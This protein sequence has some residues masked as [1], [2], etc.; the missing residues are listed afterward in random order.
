MSWRERIVQSLLGQVHHFH[1]SLYHRFLSLMMPILALVIHT[2]F[3]VLLRDLLAQESEQSQRVT[4]LSFLYAASRGAADSA[5]EIVMSRWQMKML[6]FGDWLNAIVLAQ[7]SK[8]LLF[9]ETDDAVCTKNQ[10]NI[11][12]N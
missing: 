5:L 12:T 6:I 1:P 7:F 3:I 11:H 10:S 9:N 2:E 8:N 4:R